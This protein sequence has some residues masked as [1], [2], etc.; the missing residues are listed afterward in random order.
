MGRVASLTVLKPPRILLAWL[1]DRIPLEGLDV[2]GFGS[3][4]S[5]EGDV[6][7]VEVVEEVL[8]GI[9]GKGALALLAL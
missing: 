8:R 4:F 7:G 5:R 1:V 3:K 6:T 2:E 9:R